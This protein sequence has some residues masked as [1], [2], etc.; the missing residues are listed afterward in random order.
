MEIDDATVTWTGSLDSSYLFGE[1][2][3]ATDMNGDGADEVLLAYPYHGDGYSYEGAVGVFDAS[4]MSAGNYDQED[5][6]W[7]L[8]GDKS[9]QYLGSH[10]NGHDADD[11]G[12]DDTLL[13]GRGYRWSSSSV[14]PDAACYLV[15]GRAALGSEDDVTDVARVTFTE[16]LFSS[17]EYGTSTAFGDI[18]DDGTVDMAIAAPGRND[19]YVYLSLFTSSCHLGTMPALCTNS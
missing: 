8:L 19:V 3:S 15:M 11:D 13:C 16:P 5:A 7:L 14:Y 12:Y 6:D 2:L 4:N 18:D 10:L 9:Y 17:E 1:A